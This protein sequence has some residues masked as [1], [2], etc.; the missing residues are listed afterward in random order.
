VT[1]PAVERSVE[2]DHHFGNATLAGSNAPCLGGQ[3]ELLAQGGLDAVPIEEFS[4]DLRGLQGF[5]ADQ[6]DSK[7]FLVFGSDMSD[8][9]E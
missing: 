6:L 8:G 1:E 3:P 5:F 7:R 2:I 9:T 4:F